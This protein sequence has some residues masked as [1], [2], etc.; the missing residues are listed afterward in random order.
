MLYYLLFFL[1]IKS[2]TFSLYHSLC[3][4]LSHTRSLPLLTYL[5]TCPS[6]PSLCTIHQP[7]PKTYMLFDS[8]L[9]LAAG[10][11]VFAGPGADLVAFFCRAGGGGCTAT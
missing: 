8:V 1:F 11:V 2:L 4:S 10:T 9:L 7:S 6:R 3:L 5:P